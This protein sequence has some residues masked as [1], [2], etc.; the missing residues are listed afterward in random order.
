MDRPRS[1]HCLAGL[2]LLCSLP[3]FAA[4]VY[5]S[6]D[7]NGVV[8]YSD[9]KPPDDV[10]VETLEFDQPE[11]VNSDVEAQRLEDMRETTDRMAADRM[12]REKY[13]AELRQLDA[14]TEASR[15]PAPDDLTDYNDSTPIYTGYYPYPY[16]VRRPWRP[17]YHPRPVPPIAHPPLLPSKP[18]L[19]PGVRPLP[20]NKYPASVIRQGYDPKVRAA[21]Q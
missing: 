4:T 20:G 18:N 8:T 10:L 1:L 13:R 19:P 17:P 16:P 7:A 11:P 5:K 2:V 14:E 3:V 9:V 15:A 12:A 21:L 6:I